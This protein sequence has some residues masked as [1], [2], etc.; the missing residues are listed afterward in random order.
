MTGLVYRDAADL[1]RALGPALDRA[2]A[3]GTV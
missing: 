3:S 2:A 1:R